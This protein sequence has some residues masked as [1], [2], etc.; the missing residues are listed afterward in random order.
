MRETF[1][2]DEMVRTKFFFEVGS[3]LLAK[4]DREN[5]KLV[6]I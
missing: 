1:L 4:G 5:R 6:P 2:M 3:S